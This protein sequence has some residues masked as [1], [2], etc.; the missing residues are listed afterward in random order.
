MPP[1]TAAE[2]S[3]HSHRR[4][5]WAGMPVRKENDKADNHHATDHH[6]SHFRDRH[7]NSSSLHGSSSGS[8]H[9]N[10]NRGRFGRFSCT[11]NY[12][13]SS[14]S[15]SSSSFGRAHGKH[16]GKGNTG[17]SA[18]SS[19]QLYFDKY[20]ESKLLTKYLRYQMRQREHKE[21]TSNWVFWKALPGANNRFTMTQLIEICKEDSLHLEYRVLGPHGNDETGKEGVVGTKNCDQDG[22]SCPSSHGAS[23]GKRSG[24]RRRVFSM[25]A[26]GGVDIDVANRNFGGGTGSCSR[27]GGTSGGE[28]LHG[29]PLHQPQLTA[30]TAPLSS[31]DVVIPPTSMMAVEQEDRDCEMRDGNASDQATAGSVSSASSSSLFHENP[32]SGGRRHKTPAPDIISYPPAGVYVRSVYR[33][34][35]NELKPETESLDY[36]RGYPWTM[37]K[38]EIVGNNAPAVAPASRSSSCHLTVGGGGA[39]SSVNICSAGN[40]GADVIGQGSSSSSTSGPM[41]CSEETK[42]PPAIVKTKSEVVKRLDDVTMTDT[43]TNLVSQRKIYLSSESRTI[44]ICLMQFCFHCTLCV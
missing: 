19:G 22:V 18:T 12:A 25:T 7:G 40:Y 41:Y 39:G 5:H 11:R 28:D 4:P 44:C 14:A 17:R 30:R 42:K 21:N 23:K 34:K 35:D 37:S 13:G 27:P 33:G 31:S 6:S 29:G 43:D 16:G 9:H 32:V 1:I 20:E 38:V 3:S 24:N 2:Q 10:L 26:V 15:S 36:W 8:Y